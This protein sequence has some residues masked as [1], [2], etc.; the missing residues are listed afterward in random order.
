MRQLPPRRSRRRSTPTTTTRL[1]R[2]RRAHLHGHSYPQEYRGSFF[3]AD[4]SGNFIR[5]VVLD[6]QHRAVSPAVRDRRPAPV[7]S[8]GPGRDALLPV[9]HDRRDPPDPLQRP[10][11]RRLGDTQVGYSPL[12]V[13]F[14]SAGRPTPAAARSRTRGTSAT[15]RPRPPPTRR[16]RTLRDGAH[17][18]GAPHGHQ[19][20]GLSSSTA[21]SGDGRQL[22]A[23]TDDQRPCDGT[24]VV[25]GQTVDFSGSATDAEDGALPP[26]H[27]QWTVLL[28]HNTHVH[29]FVGASV[30]GQLRRR[31]PRPDR[32]VLVRDHPH[33]DR[34]Q[35]AAVQH[36]VNLPVSARHDSA[37]GA[38][39]ADATAA[40]TN[41]RQ[42][43]VDAATDNIAV[44]GY[45]VERCQ[46][47]GCT[48]FV[49]IAAPTATTSAT[50][51][52]GVDRVSLPRARRRTS[53]Q[54]RAVLDR[55]R[56]TTD[57]APPTPP[58]WSARGRSARAPG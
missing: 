29:T 42:S 44:A 8:P 15:A 53:E 40:G 58:V 14:S 34:Q 1:G 35:R 47:A 28:H 55:R 5:R 13:A 46:G 19:H 12:T 20:A 52:H 3:F 39:V 24:S 36:V 49:E 57:A 11:R 6:D 22:T 37:D 23:D 21:T 30:A 7:S 32:H 25:P 54:P 50:R 41:R 9:V 16:T 27:L 26:R 45:R 17:V 43:G 2:D 38:G 56:R 18:H 31:E 48:D 51:P 33:G 10:G 4:Y